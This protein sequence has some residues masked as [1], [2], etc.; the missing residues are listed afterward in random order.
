[1]GSFTI[2]AAVDD[3]VY[4]PFEYYGDGRKREAKRHK[5][6]TLV[7]QDEI[8]IDRMIKEHQNTNAKII[9]SEMALDQLRTLKI[10]KKELQSKRNRLTA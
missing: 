5:M 4:I 10:T 6:Q 9:E 2:D 8:D 1:M 7:A 3:A